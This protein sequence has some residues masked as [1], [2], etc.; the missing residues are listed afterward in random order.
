MKNVPFFANLS[1]GTH[2][3]QAALKMVLTYF[4]GKEWSFDALDLLTGKLKDKWT[5]P[6]ASLIWLTE[7]GFAVK[8]VEKFS[9]R[10]FAARGKD[11]LIEK[12]GREVA[13]A[14]A[15]HSDL[16]REQALA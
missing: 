12:C 7:N 4:T 14:Q 6:T 5:W 3:Y 11:Y 13:G 8:L 2:C 15:L 1:D 10:D 16:F 9:Y